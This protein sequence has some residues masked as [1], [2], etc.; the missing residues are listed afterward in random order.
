VIALVQEARAAGARREAARAVME[1]SPRTPR[2]WR[3]EG[4]VKADGRQAAAQGRTPANRLS[5]QERS[6]LLEVVNR[7]EYASQPPSQIVPALA[8]QGRYIASESTFHRVPRDE[9]RRVQRGKAQA[10]T[11][12]HRAPPA[13]TRCGAGA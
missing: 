3:E 7:P 9:G 8:D 4:A 2:R 5:P 6:R 11:H 10:P 1:V 13:R 12:G